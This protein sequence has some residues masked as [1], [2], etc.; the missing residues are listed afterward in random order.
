MKKIALVTVTYNAE[1]N[2]SFFLPSLIRNEKSI[3]A[4]YFVDNASKDETL[5]VLQSF[6][7]EGSIH[8]PVEIILN[9]KNYGYTYAINLGI[10][11]AL[12]DGFDYICVTNND[13]IFDEGFLSQM[14]QDA[15]VN[16]VDALGVPASV[17]ADDV[18]FGYVLDSATH[19]PKKDAPA[20]RGEVLREI[21]HIS[22]L[23]VDFPHGGTI[24]FTRHFF[25]KIGLYDD[26]LFFGGDE[27]DFLYRVAAYNASHAPKMKCAVSLRAFPLMDNL[28]KHN[29][30]HKIIKAK[31]MLQGNARVNLKHR[32]TPTD[33]GLYREQYELIRNLSKGRLLRYAALYMFALRGLC[34]EI[35]RYYRMTP[36]RKSNS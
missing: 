19:L 8:A 35:T 12:D 4:V 21:A 28:T 18:G 23:P 9:T 7:D 33:F 10:R 20:K 2:L 34:I 5:P 16:G 25:E 6:K 32:F 15:T 13:I 27:L 3:D 1:R 36:S 30:G 22:L 29:T 11:K 31:R 24:L 26:K 17:N 14:L